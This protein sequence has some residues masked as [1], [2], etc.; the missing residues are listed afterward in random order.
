MSIAEKLTTIAENQQKVYDA[1]YKQGKIDGNMLLYTTGLSYLFAEAVFTDGTELEIYCPNFIRRMEGIAGAS[2]GL[3][4]L[5]LRCDDTTGGVEFNQAFNASSVEILDISNFKHTPTNVTNCFLNSKIVTVIGV[6]D[7]SLLT[8][9]LNFFQGASNIKDVTFVPNTIGCN[10]AI[11][12]ATCSTDSAK[13]AILGLKNYSET[14]NAYTCTLSLHAN[15][16]A[17]L[18]AEGATAP[19]GVTWKK[20]AD[21]LGWNT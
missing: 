8:A 9:T 19:G 3:R 10:L 7:L 4:K 14:D 20:Y 2:I 11:K 13:S 6:F 16:W 17:L 5:V 21:N 12:S 18:D 15:V 1:G